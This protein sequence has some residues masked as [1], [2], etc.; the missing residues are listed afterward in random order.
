MSPK[1]RAIVRM[2]LLQCQRWLACLLATAGAS[3]LSDRTSVR[4]GSEI[5]HLDSEV[6]LETHALHDTVGVGEAVQLWVVLANGGGPVE[7]NNHP[8]RLLF[9]V[10]TES[11]KRVDP[12][13]SSSIDVFM[14]PQTRFVL[15]RK[16]VFGQL[17]TLDCVRDGYIQREGGC[18][19]RYRLPSPG[20]YR[21]ITTFRGL[22]R[23][24]LVDTT[25]VIVRPLK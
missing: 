21:I 20:A 7:V 14:G 24:V 11:G 19:Y 22:E 10:E 23:R 13:E 16:T 15:P 17:L 9:E 1:R 4:S 3:C 2:K 18:F 25:R 8:D 12:L 6:T 5:F